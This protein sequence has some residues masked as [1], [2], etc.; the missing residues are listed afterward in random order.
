MFYQVAGTQNGSG[1][2]GHVAV[3]EGDE[4]T[5]LTVAKRSADTYRRL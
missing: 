1:T 4:A 2:R 3:V 5:E